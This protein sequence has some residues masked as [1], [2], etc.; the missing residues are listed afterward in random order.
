MIKAFWKGM[1]VIGVLWYSNA[2]QTCFIE[3]FDGRTGFVWTSDIEL[4]NVGVA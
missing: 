2:G 4:V 3:L 1:E